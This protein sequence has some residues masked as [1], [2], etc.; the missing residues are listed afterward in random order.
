M[1]KIYRGASPNGGHEW[2]ADEAP[3]RFGPEHE[4]LKDA[5]VLPWDEER[6]LR[7]AIEDGVLEDVMVFDGGEDGLAYHHACWE[8]QGSPPSTG[9]AVRANGSHGWALVE[10]YHEQLFDFA[11]LEADG[12]RWMLADPRT[13]AR[14]RARIEALVAIARDEV[15]EPPPTEVVGILEVD[16]DWACMAIRAEQQRAAIVRARTYSIEQA[17]KTGFADL[18]R[19]RVPYE[20]RQLPAGPQMEAVEALELELKEALERDRAAMLVVVAFAQGAAE[21]LAWARDGARAQG[22]IA[23]RVQRAGGRIDVQ[24]DPR[25]EEAMR[26]LTRLRR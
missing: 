13:D 14:S 4:W 7:G 18:V 20:G 16:R 22:Q 2:E 19:V 12:K 6:V 23:E 26:T 1:L 8:L 24:R 5:V 15:P 17:D 9:P 25:W 21:Y 10:G 11:G 3:F